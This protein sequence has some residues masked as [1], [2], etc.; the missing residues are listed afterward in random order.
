MLTLKAG[1]M[2]NQLEFPVPAVPGRNITFT[3]V[4]LCSYQA[5]TTPS[6]PCMSSVTGDC[7]SQHSM[8]VMIPPYLFVFGVS[9]HLSELHFA[10]LTGRVVQ[11]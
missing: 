9:P 7:L 3:T 8:V 5:F 1:T 11:A 2:K 10:L 4:F 6:R